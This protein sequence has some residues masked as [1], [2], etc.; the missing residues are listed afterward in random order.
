MFIT[1]VVVSMKAGVNYKGVVITQKQCHYTTSEKNYDV[2]LD[3][4]MSKTDL[5]NLI[6]NKETISKLYVR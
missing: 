3:R 2:K 4:T 6:D 1:W 5:W